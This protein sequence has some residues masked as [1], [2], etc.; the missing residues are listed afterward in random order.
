MFAKLTSGFLLMAL[1]TLPLAAQ[2]SNPPTAPTVNVA[3]VA[4]ITV[5]AGKATQVPI[6]FTLT[7]GFH[8]NSNVPR[9]E[10]L[11]PTVLMLNAPAP[12][13]TFDIA[14]PKGED[15]AFDFAPKEKLN[16]YTGEFILNVRVKAARSAAAGTHKVAGD[17]RYQACNDR[18]CFP[19]KKVPVAFDLVVTK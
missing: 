12:A 14:Y 13:I 17:L 19:P 8:V 9:S 2:W 4:P 5:A 3:P 1:F 15:V 7:K 6:R 10:L 16:V 18:A 11:I